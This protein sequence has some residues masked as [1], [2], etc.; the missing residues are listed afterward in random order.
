MRRTRVRIF[1]ARAWVMPAAVFMATV[2]I[3][4]PTLAQQV[5]TP[6]PMSPGGAFTLP[7]VNVLATSGLWSTRVDDPQQAP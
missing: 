6:S 5:L 4:A 2:G 7:T 1:G 3:A